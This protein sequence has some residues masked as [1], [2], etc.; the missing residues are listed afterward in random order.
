MI[1]VFAIAIAISS[2]RVV[3]VV[4]DAALTPTGVRPPDIF[5]LSVWTGWVITLAVAELWIRYTRPRRA[6]A[7]G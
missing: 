2:V 1:G 3:G 7:G 6:L 5:V 4:L